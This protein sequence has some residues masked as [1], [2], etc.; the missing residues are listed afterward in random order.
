[1]QDTIQRFI[2]DEAPVR[3]EL[4]SLNQSWQ[5]ILQRHDYPAVLKPVLGELCAAAFLLTAMLKLDGSLIMQIHGTGPVR[6]IVVECTSELTIRA[7]VKWD[8]TQPL[9]NVPLC[10]LLK[11][12]KFVITLEQEGEQAPYQGIVALEGDSVAEMIMHY[13]QHS[14]QLDTALWLYANDEVACGLLLQRL[15]G[16]PFESDDW[17]RLTMLAQ[18]VTPG[19]LT[20]LDNRILLHRLFPEEDIRIFEPEHVSFAC[21]CSAERVGNMLQMLGREEVQ[22]V[23]AER[24][25]IEVHC[26]FCNARYEYDAVD[27]AGLFAGVTTLNA[28]NTRQ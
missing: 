28:V 2:F 19:E 15:P 3:G 14:E 4:V 27:V 20:E 26:E 25:T 10:T 9:P 11:D 8:E 22:S 21:T 6:L 5:S 13:M 16:E 7:T 12:G 24:G 23:L 18:T 17:T 1:M